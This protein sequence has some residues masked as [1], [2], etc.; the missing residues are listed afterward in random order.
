METK[1]VNDNTLEV[2][3][4]VE[5]EVEE[6]EQEYSIDDLL[7]LSADEYEEFSDDAQHKGMQ[8]LAHWMQHVPED[9]RKHLA[10]IRADYTRKTQSLAEERNQLRTE[11]Q[12]ERDALQA[13]RK[14]LYNGNMA[15]Q[16]R[17]I[18]AD[19]TEYDMFDPEG[20]KK[21]IQREAA[22][23]LNDMLK[24]AQED[25][26]VQQRKLELQ[27]FRDQHPDIIQ[28]EYR[29]PIA[30]MLQSRPELKLED[31]YYIVK[32]KVDANKASQVLSEK[33]EERKRKQSSFKKTSTGTAGK[34]NGTPQFRDSWQAYLW[35]K[36]QGVK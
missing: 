8:P 32:A 15:K 23:M 27:R 20:M 5:T 31:A 30:E 9:V 17:E 1:T 28:D 11:L 22:K 25:L 34:P 10:N 21:Q 35:H 33:E 2:E 26:Q 24:P 3:E 14:A 13:E 4:A 7:K 16:V 12:A 19:E 18:S 36:S 6:V 29:M